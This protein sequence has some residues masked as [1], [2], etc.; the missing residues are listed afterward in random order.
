MSDESALSLAERRHD[1]RQDLGVQSVDI[2]EHVRG[3]ELR[4]VRPPPRQQAEAG[5]Q[6]QGGSGL[7]RDHRDHGRG[8]SAQSALDRVFATQAGRDTLLEGATAVQVPQMQSIRQCAVASGPVLHPVDDATLDR[9]AVVEQ[10]LTEHLRRA[11]R[12][13][14]HGQVRQPRIDRQRRAGAHGATPIRTAIG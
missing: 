13:D 3:D 11:A 1:L 10:N 8:G 12:I 2:A 4:V 7:G 5:D 6:F 14:D 9:E